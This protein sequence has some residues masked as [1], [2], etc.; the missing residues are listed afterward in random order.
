MRFYSFYD[1]SCLKEFSFK[2]NVRGAELDKFVTIF[3]LQMEYMYTCD[4]FL[5]CDSVSAL[6]V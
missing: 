2:N 1:Q 4:S 6:C 3:V 5:T